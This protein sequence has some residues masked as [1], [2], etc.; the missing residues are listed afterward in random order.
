MLGGT[1]WVALIN[2]RLETLRGERPPL[3]TSIAQ[4]QQQPEV[5]GWAPSCNNSDESPRRTM[6]DSLRITAA[7]SK[8]LANASR[9][10]PNDFDISAPRGI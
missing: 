10:S 5:Q 6:R 1:V 9:D 7:R 2:A 4:H 3:A 8:E